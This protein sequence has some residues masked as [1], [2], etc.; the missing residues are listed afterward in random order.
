MGHLYS[1]LRD[2]TEDMKDREGARRLAPLFSFYLA[3]KLW[4]VAA[5]GAWIEV[6]FLLTN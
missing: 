6:R 2:P 3:K 5:M 1:W 4:Y